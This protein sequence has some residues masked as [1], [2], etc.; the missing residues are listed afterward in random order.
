MLHAAVSCRGRWKANRTFAIVLAGALGSLGCPQL[1]EDDFSPP[2]VL[3]AGS[4]PNQDAS[5]NAAGGAGAIDNSA[6]SSGAVTGEAGAGYT[7]GDGGTNLFDPATCVAPTPIACDDQCRECCADTDCAS[8]RVCLAGICAPD[9]D[10]PRV[11]CFD[12]CVNLTL[13]EDNCGTCGN[14]CGRGRTC[15]T[16]VC[17][18]AW[19]SLPAPPSAL[20]A[21]ERPAQTAMAGKV[22]IWGGADAA[23][24]AL[25]SGASYD[26]SNNRWTN[27]PTDANTPSARVNASAL[28]TGTEVIVWGGGDPDAQTDYADGARYN[29]TLNEWQPLAGSGAPSARRSAHVFWTGSRMLLWSGTTLDAGPIESDRIHSYDPVWN[30]WDTASATGTRPPSD[31]ADATLAWSGSVLYVFGGRSAGTDKNTF[32]EYDPAQSRWTTR[33]QVRPHVATRLAFGTELHSRSGVAS[34]G[35][36]S[37]PTA[38]AGRRT[39]WNPTEVTGQPSQPMAL[40]VVGRRPV[41]RDGAST[42]VQVRRC[43]SVVPTCS[44]TT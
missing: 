26:P 15:Q 36:R 31:L 17:D 29:P 28:W 40:S 20:V 14:A 19:V 13:D 18:P 9:C 23:G 34:R 1:L 37:R 10:S 32:F 30:V 3:A 24:T 6:G 12:S 7:P 43:S 16:G 38:N 44:R 22:F 27:L 11:A 25:A 33:S 21:R 39:R 8:G 5:T 35:A 2:E 4:G 41:K 42:S